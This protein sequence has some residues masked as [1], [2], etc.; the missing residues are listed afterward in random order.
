[1]IEKEFVKGTIHILLLYDLF[2][3]IS[4]VIDI[5]ALRLVALESLH[6]LWVE[7]LSCPIDRL[8]NIFYLLYLKQACLILEFASL[9]RCKFLHW[10][11]C[12]S[13]YRLLFYSLSR[14]H[15]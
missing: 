6:D 12:W 5:D 13:L 7:Y 14:H 10:I 1:M 15:T 3:S 4:E 11:F 9:S 8:E 2:K